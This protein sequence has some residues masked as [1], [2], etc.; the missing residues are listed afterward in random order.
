MGTGISEYTTLPA[1][2]DACFVEKHNIDNII[3]YSK[4][5]KIVLVI[6]LHLKGLSTKNNR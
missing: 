5:I 6:L 4:T 2:N 1:V 3:E